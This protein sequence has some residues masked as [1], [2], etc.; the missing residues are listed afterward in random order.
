MTG[1]S[2]GRMSSGSPKYTNAERMRSR[3]ATGKR[4]SSSPSICSIDSSSGSRSATKSG[5]G[6]ALRISSMTPRMASM[7]SDS[8]ALRTT[9]RDRL[10]AVRK[11]RRSLSLSSKE[12]LR[13]MCNSG[14][15]RSDRLPASMR[16]VNEYVKS[17]ATPCAAMVY[18]G[19]G[20]CHGAC[21]NFR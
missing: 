16:P 15:E 8:S 4:H 21:G 17:G 13:L 14:P 11:K 20:V 6:S 3:S 2:S 12:I 10:S 9:S 7:I 1:I 18:H 5:R 19:V